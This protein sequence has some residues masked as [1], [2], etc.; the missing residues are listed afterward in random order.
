MPVD[1]AHIGHTARDVEPFIRQVF[2]G[3]GKRHAGRHARM[4]A[5][6]HSQAARGRR[7]RAARLEQKQYCYVPSLSSRVIIYKGLMLADQVER[8]YH[9]LADE[10]FVSALALV[11]QR[12]STNTFPTWDLAHPFRFLAHNGEIN[13][14]RGNVNWMHARQS[15]LASEMYGPDLKKICPICTPGASDSAMF[16]NALELLVLTGRSL[17]QAMSMLIPEPWAGPREH[18]RRQE[19][20]LRISGLPDGA[21]GR[22]GVDGLYRRHDDR[23]RARPQRPASQPLLGDQGR[24]GGHGLGSRRAGHSAAAT[25]CRRAA[26]GR[27][28]CSWST[29]SQGRIIADDEIKHALAS[30]HPYRQWLDENQIDARRPARPGGAGRTATWTSRCCT[31]QRAFGYTLED[32]RILMAPMAADGQEAIGSMGNDTPLAVLSDR[33]QLLYNY[34]KQLFAQVTNPPLDA[35]REEIITSLVTTIGSEGNLLD[36]TP[37]QCRLLRLDQPILTNT[38]LARIKQ[39]DSARAARAARC[40]CSFRARK[41]PPG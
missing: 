4:E 34:F 16:D 32:L 8:F 1:N 39:L 35:I 21:L 26:C 18:V 17:P 29:P 14:L 31:L 9:D 33:P 6:R 25:S 5:V 22:P 28:A 40:R 20:L 41:A 13:T 19:G 30:R 23:R 2:I 15:M 38:D 24:A 36:E 7:P 3:R 12:Y 37:E 11:H 10:R 27:A